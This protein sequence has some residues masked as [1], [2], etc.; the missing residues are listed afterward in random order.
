MSL[1]D[2]RVLE[3]TVI[4]TVRKSFWASPESEVFPYRV[5]SPIVI[6]HSS[7]PFNAFLMKL[8]SLWAVFYRQP[9]VIVF[10]SAFKVMPLFL[11]LKKIGLLKKVK[12]IAIN[13]ISFREEELSGLDRVII[14]YKKEEENYQNV[15]KGKCRFIPLPADGNFEQIPKSEEID[16]FSGGGEGR[17]FKT[18]FEAVRGTSWKVKVVTF[19]SKNIQDAGPIPENVVVE[20]KMPLDRF[21]REMAKSKIVVIPLR[22]GNWPHGHTSVVQA[23]CLEKPVISNL[24]SSVDDYI[25][26]GVN[27]LLVPSND[28][29]KLKDSI[30]EML[31]NQ[32]WLH[33][34]KGVMGLNQ[35]LNYKSFSESLLRVI[36]EVLL[37]TH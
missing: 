23:L 13:R 25:Q 30:E 5:F 7:H 12:F 26:N 9:K 36:N 1:P 28:A 17:D 29:L 20:Y 31:T 19:S 32:H 3:K 16:I 18:L 35:N 6:G 37:E 8:K 24:D 15:L 34:K 11:W 22:L 33:Y 21:L 10:G 14:Y 4:L 27:G 2:S